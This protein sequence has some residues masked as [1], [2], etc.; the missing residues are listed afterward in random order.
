MSRIAIH[1]I[2]AYLRTFN[3]SSF[4][5]VASFPFHDALLQ[6]NSSVADI[7]DNVVG[8]R[9]AT[10]TSRALRL[11]LPFD[12]IDAALETMSRYTTI[13]HP[14]YLLSSYLGSVLY[15]SQL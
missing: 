13:Y 3:S 8:G 11:E 15:P 1:N 10:R 9:D 4:N 7:M 2:I 5:S 14:L 6:V 12:R